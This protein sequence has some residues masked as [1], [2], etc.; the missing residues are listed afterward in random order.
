MSAFIR[1]ASADDAEALAALTTIVQGLHAENRPDQFRAASE[2]EIAEWYRTM[3]DNPRYHVWIAE[4]DGRPAGY[5]SAGF[6]ER[7][8]T[9]FTPA[10][11][12]CELD[13]IAVDARF[14]LRGI[15]R[16]LFDTVV[17][18]ARAEGLR[19]IETV[20]WSFNNEAHET[21]RRF[22][23]TPKLLRFELILGDESR[24]E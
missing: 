1:P 10:K 24:D 6:H 18:K 5:V 23:F 2:A 14:R 9:P 3:L 21:F 17:N 20:S 7:P 8:A 12:W 4:V 19:Q 13:Q 16:A 15:A 11:R 22:G